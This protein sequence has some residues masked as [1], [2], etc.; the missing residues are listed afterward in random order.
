MSTPEEKKAARVL[1][2]D[3]EENV[4]NSLKR[5]FIDTGMEIVLAPSGKAGLEILKGNEIAVIIS[6]QRMPEM[7][8]AD[9]LAFSREISP[10]SIRIVLTGYADV[11]TAIKAIN[12]GGAYRYITKPW[13]DNELISTVKAAAEKYHLLRENRY[14]TEL[15]RK[16]NEELKRW[17]AELEIYVQ[18]QTIDLTNQ[19]KKLKQLNGR[20]E[21]QLK[22]FISSF[23]D[24]IELRDRTVYSHSSH[25]AAMSKGV[26]LETGFGQEEAEMVAVA[27]QL[28]DIGKI[29]VPDVILIKS[30]DELSAEETVE[31]R[32]HSIRG[33]VALAALEEFKET[34]L[35]IRHHHENFDGSGFPDG[36]KGENIPLGARIIAIAD[37]FDRLVKKAAGARIEDALKKL[38]ESLGTQFDPALY[39]PVEKLAREDAA[40]LVRQAGN[41]E[42]ELSL[43]DVAPGMVLSREVRSG[44]GLLLLGMGSVLNEKTIEILRKYYS[45]DPHRSGIFV[46]ITGKTPRS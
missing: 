37:R 45:V 24:L 10:D 7:S 42:I 16:Q 2:V 32:K 39:G 22:E 31:Y 1:I 43:S 13:N 20:L 19:N 28:H 30:P 34:G 27:A 35:L 26:A 33:Q 21:G 17:S 25:V 9:F 23:S 5:L 6:D 36:L 46:R 44:T 40:S 41:G 4:R 38:R 29:G 18:Q 8:G 12:E 15:T 11:N 14:L 3:D